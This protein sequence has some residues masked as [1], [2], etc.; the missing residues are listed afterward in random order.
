ML[1]HLCNVVLVKYVAD[2]CVQVNPN[3]LSESQCTAGE[4]FHLNGRTQMFLKIDQ[5]LLLKIWFMTETGT[6]CMQSL[7]V[8]SLV[9][10]Y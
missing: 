3:A 5:R 6:D 9:S 7:D 2:L 10:V 4:C 8:S 1:D